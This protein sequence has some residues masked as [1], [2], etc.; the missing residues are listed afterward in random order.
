MTSEYNPTEL[1][2]LTSDVP[3]LERYVTLAYLP[4]IVCNSGHHLVRPLRDNEM[5]E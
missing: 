5:N 3:D 4:K 1:L 2:L